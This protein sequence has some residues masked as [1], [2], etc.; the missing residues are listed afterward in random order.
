MGANWD[1]KEWLSLLESLKQSEFWP[2]NADE[3]GAVLE[4]IKKEWHEKQQPRIE[5]PASH[6]VVATAI[7]SPSERSF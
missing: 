6:P 2:M 7:T 5:E 1:H 3:I 4:E